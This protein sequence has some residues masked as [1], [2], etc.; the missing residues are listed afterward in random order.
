[1]NTK[2]LKSK[3]FAG[4]DQMHGSYICVNLTIKLALVNKK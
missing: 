3:F 1:M 4:Q 2:D